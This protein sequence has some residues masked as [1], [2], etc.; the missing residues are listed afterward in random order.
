[1]R[2]YGISLFISPRVFVA[3]IGGV[4]CCISSFGENM[5]LPL[6]SSSSLPLGGAHDRQQGAG[7]MQGLIVANQPTP[8]SSSLI[9]ERHT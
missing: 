9:G 6:Y 1:M 8:L 2:Y 4:A 7:L 5:H 3:D